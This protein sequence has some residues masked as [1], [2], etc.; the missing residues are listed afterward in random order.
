MNSLLRT[1]VFYCWLTG[2]TRKQ[3]IVFKGDKMNLKLAVVTLW[4]NDVMRA[5]DFYRDVMGL[6]LLFLD[7]GRPHFG[8]GRAYLLILQGQPQEVK[9]SVP[10]R[11]PVLAFGVEDLDEAIQHLKACG[12][13]LP[14]GIEEDAHT[15]WVM[16]RDPAGNLL[17]IAKFGAGKHNS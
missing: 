9:D 8:L 15:R 4:S 5:T 6:P 14:W 3:Q 16:F 13:E 11:F 17:E 7:R 1:A 10:P 12:V 2:Q